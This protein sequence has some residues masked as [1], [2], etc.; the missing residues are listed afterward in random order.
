M[1][2]G[3]KDGTD[4]G[5][6]AV[7]QRHTRLP[8]FMRQTIGNTEMVNSSAEFWFSQPGAGAKA[9]QD[10][11]CQNTMSIQLSGTKRWRIG[12]PPRVPRV[13]DTL[14]LHDGFINASKW[15]PLYELILKE[16]E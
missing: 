13:G 12:P 9:H 2:W 1:Y 15:K 16:G 4:G 5:V 11:H 7:V 6:K 10:S 3:V 8:Y 14:P